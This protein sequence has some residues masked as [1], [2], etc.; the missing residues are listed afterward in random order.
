MTYCSQA[1]ALIVLPQTTAVVL[2]CSTARSTYLVTSSAGGSLM[3]TS[4]HHSQ[5]D[6]ASQYRTSSTERLADCCFPML[7]HPAKKPRWCISCGFL[8]R[9]ALEWGIYNTFGLR[10]CEVGFLGS[11][12]PV[13]DRRGFWVLLWKSCVWMSLG[14]LLIDLF[15]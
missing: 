13:L 2:G 5:K 3:E 9:A 10:A 1:P 11:L 8:D 14:Y 6:V 4:R 7:L 15:P 12:Q